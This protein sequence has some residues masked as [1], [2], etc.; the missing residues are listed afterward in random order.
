L[1]S[2]LVGDFGRKEKNKVESVG[3]ITHIY[4]KMSQANQCIG[5]L[6]KQKYHI[7]GEVGNSGSCL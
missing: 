2:P 7:L 1:K 5:I 6:N 3:V 4:M